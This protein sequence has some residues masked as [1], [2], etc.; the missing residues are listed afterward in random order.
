MSSPLLQTY[1][2]SRIS[3]AELLEASA[4][5]VLELRV[6]ERLD[7]E[8]QLYADVLLAYHAGDRARLDERTRQ[9][10]EL[11]SPEA[12][13]L[14]ILSQL[15]LGLLNASPRSLQTESPKDPLFAAEAE[16]LSG[17]QQ[18]RLQERDLAITHFERAADLYRTLGLTRKSVKAQ[19]NAYTL[20]CHN[21]RPSS[22]QL[23]S[24][25]RKWLDRGLIA[26]ETT[27][28]ATAA[29]N[30]SQELQ[31]IGALNLALR[32]CD[33]GLRI[34]T[35][36]MYSNAH[37]QLLLQRCQLLFLL[38]RPSP[39]QLDLDLLQLCELPMISEATRVIENRFLRSEHTIRPELLSAAWK[40][41]SECVNWSPPLLREKE[42]HLLE[43]LIG[44]PQ[45]PEALCSQLWPE[46]KSDPT[47]RAR[48]RDLVYRCNQRISGLIS[49]RDGIYGLTGVHAPK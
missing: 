27:V 6:H 3:F 47:R 29:L 21:T 38:Q 22:A 13:D 35:E 25:N 31:S 23:I 40:A 7:Q 37:F 10:A 30:L 17:L 11:S 39:A 18:S 42:E 12:K 41:R 32:T 43:L 48:L 20:R 34:L 33:E 26:R 49:H 15:R 14:S 36:E 2:P 45:T 5:R 16:F 19:F 1:I 24:E 46:V 8:Q 44:S 9:L 28:A 4:S